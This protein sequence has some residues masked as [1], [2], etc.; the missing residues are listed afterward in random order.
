MAQPY[1]NA[2]IIVI[3]HKLYTM[4]QLKK[5]IATLSAT[6]STTWQQG[7]KEREQNFVRI[8]KHNYKFSQ[9]KV[10]NLVTCFLFYIIVYN[11]D[12]VKNAKILTSHLCLDNLF[13]MNCLSFQ[14]SPG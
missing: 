12:K 5:T 3:V 9:S 8:Q 7:E 4:E 13:H 10:E 14:S 11:K 6:S 2:S 1:D